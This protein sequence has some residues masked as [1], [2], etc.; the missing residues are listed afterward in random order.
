MLTSLKSVPCVISSLTF[1]KLAPTPGIVNTKIRSMAGICAGCPWGSVDWISNRRRGTEWNLWGGYHSRS[2]PTMPR[3]LL[4]P[5]ITH[6]SRVFPHTMGSGNPI[7]TCSA[8]NLQ[9]IAAA[10]EMK[11]FPKPISSTTSAPGTSASETHHLTMNQMAQT[12][13]AKNLV[14]GRPGI[15]YLRPGTR[16]SVDWRIGSAFCS[17]TS[18]SRH[19]CSNL[20]L[21]VL[22]TVFSTDLVFSG[23]RTSSQSSTS[24]WTSL[25]SL[26]VFYS[27]SIIPF[28]CLDVSWAD[29][30]MIWR[31]WNS[32]QC[33]I[34][35]RYA[36]SSTN[37][38]GWN[39]VNSILSIRTYFN[40]S[41]ILLPAILLSLPF[42]LSSTH[43]R[44]F[45]SLCMMISS[46]SRV[47][48][49][50]LAG[51]TFVGPITCLAISFPV[52]LIISTKN[53]FTLC[54]SFNLKAFERQQLYAIRPYMGSLIIC[55]CV[56]HAIYY[57]SNSSSSKVHLN[58]DVRMDGSIGLLFLS[59]KSTNSSQCLT[60]V[61]KAWSCIGA[62]TKSMPFNTQQ[63][64]TV[65]VLFG[66]SGR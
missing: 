34:F 63:I 56:Y 64:I 52:A 25:A 17:L 44:I 4:C 3:K 51:I 19:L 29:M 45:Q 24:S 9:R 26:S 40:R 38:C 55:P 59:M 16:S 49:T 1:S 47:P 8:T 23:W 48:W 5:N 61:Y 54:P 22:R 33:Y 13:C 66:N 32:S 12:W 28:S 39:I 15:K 27:S 57:S 35:H 50:L 65:N 41:I 53:I 62:R 60:S 36:T 11:V 30:L 43:F 2:S 20:W 37:T 31:S 14:A 42:S 58:N 7:T 21:I 10:T 6:S 18:S 46:C